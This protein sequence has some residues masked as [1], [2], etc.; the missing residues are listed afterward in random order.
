VHPHGIFYVVGEGEGFGLLWRLS[1]SELGMGWFPLAV[2]GKSGKKKLCKIRLMEPIIGFVI[3][4][5]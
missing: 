3:W 5:V 1:S 2:I 4:V